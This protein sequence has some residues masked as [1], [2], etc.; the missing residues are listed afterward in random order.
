M[1]F[2]NQ[3]ILSVPVCSFKEQIVAMKWTWGGTHAPHI[4]TLTPG[5]NI[6]VIHQA[7]GNGPPDTKVVDVHLHGCSNNSPVHFHKINWAP[8]INCL[9]KTKGLQSPRSLTVR[10]GL[11]EV[12]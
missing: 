3:M 4:K 12:L 8:P 2:T 10:G 1:T 9:T 6:V 7:T 5:K 11:R